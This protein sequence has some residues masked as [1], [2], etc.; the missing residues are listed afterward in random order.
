MSKYT[1]GPWD[2]KPSPISQF[3]SYADME[4]SSEHTPGRLIARIFG[5]LPTEDNAEVNA[6][7]RLIAASPTMHGACLDMLKYLDT[8][9][10]DDELQAENKAAMIKII[11]SAI[12]GIDA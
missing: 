12:S 7:A 1:K 3:S 2:A 8:I 5:K 4:I 9:G 11:N 10:C 6:N